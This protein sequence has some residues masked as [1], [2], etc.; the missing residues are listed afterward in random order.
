M[1]EGKSE[2]EENSILV[3][4]FRGG[5]IYKKER[6]KVENVVKVEK[7]ENE[8]FWVFRERILFCFVLDFICFFIIF[9]W[10]VCFLFC[11]VFSLFVFV[12]TC[13]GDKRVVPP[14][15]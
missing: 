13:Q 3:E 1:K 5:V 2:I 10:F 14:C 12:L 8:F 6:K 4:S 11:F 15:H 7:P 9:L